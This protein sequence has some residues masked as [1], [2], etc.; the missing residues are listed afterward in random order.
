[1][2]M[3]IIL[4]AAAPAASTI[5]IAMSDY[6]FDEWDDSQQAHHQQQQ[7]Q[8][9]SQKADVEE[10][11]EPLSDQDIAS[12]ADTSSESNAF[13]DVPISTNTRA[14]T[15]PRIFRSS[16]QS[17]FLS[18]YSLPLPPP[19][20]HT[21]GGGSDESFL[22]LH[23][24]DNH[25]LSL[26]APLANVA[27]GVNAD[28]VRVSLELAYH[29]LTVKQ[30][31]Y[32]AESQP[33]LAQIEFLVLILNTIS[34]LHT[35]QLQHS[36][37]DSASVSDSKR[38]RSELKWLSLAWLKQAEWLCLSVTN[39]SAMH[40]MTLNNLASVYRLL[41]KPRTSARLVASAIQLVNET[42]TDSDCDSENDREFSILLYHN[43]SAVC[44]TLQCYEESAIYAKHSV[45]EC[46]HLLATHL[47]DNSGSA[48][49]PQSI[50][51][52]L[53]LCYHSLA[54][55]EQ[56]LRASSCIPWFERAI[57]TARLADDSALVA[58]FHE[59]LMEA[60]TL[61]VVWATERETMKL[62]LRSQ[63]GWVTVM[64]RQRARSRS[65]SRSR[66]QR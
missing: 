45:D 10:T 16:P 28:D 43:L 24:L 47:A 22:L 30:T 14:S 66:N 17:P 65:R 38:V 26:L 64:A 62:E 6:E 4:C 34:A 12:N 40:A 13:T 32:G 50:L 5:T 61:L 63:R 15:R 57:N 55:A 11:K 27:T 39:M 25:C 46:Q 48:N 21:G 2:F 35:Q 9:T 44:N 33:V 42:D 31:L 20:S 36:F 54:K 51:R 41:N 23:E 7:Q 56:S 58:Q 60:R 19:P 37:T 3:I 8:C 29:S 59:S 53:C 1:M 49:N 18:A 52:L